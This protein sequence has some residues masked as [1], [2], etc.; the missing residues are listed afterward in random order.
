MCSA[1]LRYINVHARTHSPILHELPF[2][3]HGTLY[4]GVL[5]GKLTVLGQ[6]RNSPHFIVPE[7]SLPGSQKPATCSYPG[8]DE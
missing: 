6:L 3:D 8:P 2:Y 7:G 1:L 4:S 5:L